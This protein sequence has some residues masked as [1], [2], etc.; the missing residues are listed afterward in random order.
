MAFLG[1][2][3]K[4]FTGLIFVLHL[5]V[6]GGLFTRPLK[7]AF[8]FYPFVFFDLR[9]F[10]IKVYEMLLLGVHY[11]VVQSKDSFAQKLTTP[12]QHGR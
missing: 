6:K 9:Q 1:R 5:K 7:I 11:L 2:L 4:G 10:S 3:A 12:I 8:I